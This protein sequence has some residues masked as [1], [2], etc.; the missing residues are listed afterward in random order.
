MAFI[1]CI[2]VHPKTGDPCTLDRNHTK[3]DDPKVQQHVAANGVKWPLLSEI[4]PDEGYN[5]FV[6]FRN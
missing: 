2:K 1:Q 5:D 4:D 6:T 3:D